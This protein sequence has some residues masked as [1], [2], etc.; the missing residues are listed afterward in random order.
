MPLRRGPGKPT[1]SGNDIDFPMVSDT[2]AVVPCMI[3][4]GAIDNLAGSGAPKPI[5]RLRIF[6]DWQNALEKIAS[7]MYDAG[8]VHAGGVVVITPRDLIRAGLIP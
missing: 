8:L 3:T 1:V 5:A 7:D 6:F 2:G 4:Q